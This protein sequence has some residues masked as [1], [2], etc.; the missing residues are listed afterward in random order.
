MKKTFKELGITDEL[1]SALSKQGIKE[2]TEVQ[3]NTIPDILA[4]NNVIARAET[5]SGKTL[6]YLL[7][8]FMKI[9]TSLRSAQCIILT[10]THEL[11]VQVHRQ[12]E[13][14]AANSG[15]EVRSALII[16]NAGMQRQ[17]D[18]LKE[19]PHII[20]GSAGRIY[21][22]IGKKKIPAHTVKTIV[23]DE[24]DRMLDKMNLDMVRAIVKTTLKDSRQM[25]F[26]SASM[27]PDAVKYASEMCT[28]P[29][30]F[31]MAEEKLPS[32]ISHF[33][34]TADLRDKI[35]IIRKIVHGE[36][37]KKT[38][39]FINN[40]EN[41]EVTV[42][43]LCYH[44]LKAVGLYGGIR[45]DERRKAINDMISGKAE[46]LVASDLVSRGLD[47]PGVTHIINLDIPENSTSYL[48]RAGRTG[49][50]GKS[51][52]VISISTIGERRYVNKCAKE[53]GIQIKYVQMREGKMVPEGDMPK[54]NVFAKKPSG[55]NDRSSKERFEKSR[56]AAKDKY[57]KGGTSEKSGRDKGFKTVH[58]KKNSKNK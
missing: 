37:A 11:A 33:C 38:I 21:D 19:K 57:S 2:P 31:C 27:D 9:D 20:I 49:R 28:V 35:N 36:K 30:V 50:G 15:M 4:K 5:G 34:I 56:P 26:L 53:L 39:V 6:T 17:L 13:L 58:I 8:I 54:R 43:K 24:A 12:A 32:S 45:R 18:K 29:P 47:I 55:K 1:I 44:T 40:P 41:I 48:H 52:K 51:G 3:E 10:P 46:I 7:P 14:L 23:V 16:G 25:I 22:F 42:E